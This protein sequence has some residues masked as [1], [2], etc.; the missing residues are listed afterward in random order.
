MTPTAKICRGELSQGLWCIVV[1]FE[2]ITQ[3]CWLVECDGEYDIIA[4]FLLGHYGWGRGEGRACRREP[5]TNLQR[6]TATNLPHFRQITASQCPNVMAPLVFWAPNLAPD[7]IN[8]HN[9]V[10][11][12]VNLSPSS[13]SHNGHK[14]MFLYGDIGAIWQAFGTHTN[15]KSYKRL[16]P[17]GGNWKSTSHT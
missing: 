9:A 17:E 8:S 14:T 7:V 13:S 12:A 1:E 2:V 15:H 6:S 5:S 16:T 4:Y 10:Q 11:P 3:G